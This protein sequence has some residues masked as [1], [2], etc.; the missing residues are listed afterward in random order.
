MEKS[1]PNTLS[2]TQCYYCA[3][4]PAERERTAK[5]TMYGNIRRSFRKVEYDRTELSVPRCRQCQRLHTVVSFC[6]MIA[7]LLLL[8]LTIW[9]NVALLPTAYRGTGVLLAL[10]LAVVGGIILGSLLGKRI[11]LQ[12]K[13]IRFETDITSL[14]AANRL[15]Q[16]GWTLNRP[17]P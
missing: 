10:F 6:R 3:I 2:S 4:H 15:I 13:H 11:F 1:M 17:T 12:P 7:I 14:P 16:N 9:L 8:P 5:V